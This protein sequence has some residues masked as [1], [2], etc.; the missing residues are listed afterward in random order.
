MTTADAT[1][2]PATTPTCLDCEYPL[3]GLA[4]NQCPECGRAFD[5]AVR[6]TMG[7]RIEPADTWRR[8]IRAGVIVQVVIVFTALSII[9]YGFAEVGVTA[10]I[11]H[12]CAIA[13]IRVRRGDQADESDRAIALAGTLAFLLPATIFACTIP[14]WVRTLVSMMLRA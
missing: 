4:H 14:G 6:E 10:A 9:A 12:W 11:A 1:G 7:P 13:I 8:A 5:P 2:S 3:T